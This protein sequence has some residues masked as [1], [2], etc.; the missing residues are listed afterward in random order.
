[1]SSP[2]RPFQYV[3]SRDFPELLSQLGVSLIVS[4]YQAGRLAVL[5]SREGRV[6]LILRTFERAM[7]VAVHRDRLAVGTRYQVWFLENDR[8]LLK[9]IN[10]LIRDALRNPFLGMGKPEPL[11]SDFSGYWSR[12]INSE[13]RLVYGVSEDE[14]VILTCRYHYHT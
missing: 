7:G 1:M 9:R 10:N 14:I 12:R 6:S 5:R 2:K 11:K 3:H 4:T 8:R 13:H